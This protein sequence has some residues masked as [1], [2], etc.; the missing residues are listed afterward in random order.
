MRNS[1]GKRMR[2]FLLII[3]T[4]NLVVS[5]SSETPKRVYEENIEI[6]EI[7]PNR[8]TAIAKQNLFHLA[9]IYDLKPFLFTKKI[10]IQSYVVPHSHPVLTLNTRHAELP[11]QLLSTWLHEEYH[12]WLSLHAQETDAAVR[13]FRKLYPKVPSH[14]NG[15]THSSYLHLAICYLEYQ[16][17]VH[18]LG[19]SEARKIIHVI[20]EKDNIYP[21][22]YTQ[23][24]K[25]DGKIHDVLS[26][27]HLLP[28]PLK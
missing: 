17:L 26:R 18:F 13:E 25:N 9:K 7:G 23:V 21:W 5:C 19:E 10:H 2:L 3:F 4:F 24:L 6:T 11:N 15:S 14:V 28:P 12:W 8:R 27:H 20:Q 22:I 16:T 1:D